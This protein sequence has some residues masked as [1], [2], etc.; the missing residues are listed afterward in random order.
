[1]LDFFQSFPV[2][3]AWPPVLLRIGDGD[4]DDA[5]ALEE[6]VRSSSIVRCLSFHTFVIFS[7][8]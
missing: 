2:T 1:M 6:G 7:Y 5:P 8:I 3:H 4:P